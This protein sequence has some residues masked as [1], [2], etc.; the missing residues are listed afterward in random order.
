MG[1]YK[2]RGEGVEKFR[3]SVIGW[4]FSKEP[5]VEKFL[6]PPQE[7]TDRQSAL[8]AVVRLVEDKAHKRIADLEG[9]H[10]GFI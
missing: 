9:E 7:G 8:M 5:S 4:D 3:A 1:R 2:S 10:A 6:V